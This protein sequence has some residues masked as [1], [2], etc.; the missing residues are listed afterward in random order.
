MTLHDG[1]VLALPHEGVSPRVSL[2]FVTGGDEGSSSKRKR[3]PEPDAAALIEEL[4]MARNE[5]AVSAA[6]LGAYKKAAE[7][8]K[9][10]AD[11][12]VRR[13]KALGEASAAAFA[14]LER[15]LEDTRRRLRAAQEE[16]RASSDE[17]M[18]LCVEA[19]ELRALR[20]A[21]ADAKGRL[22]ERET[23]FHATVAAAHAKAVQCAAD[24]AQFC[25]ESVRTPPQKQPEWDSGDY[26]EG[27]RF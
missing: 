24:L 6:R 10:E 2:R 22:H 17:A 15:E 26:E 13:H 1:D 20:R 8:A 3:E 19:A 21:M 14:D 9:A 4:R 16:L 12:D 5:A 27:Q 25:H 7:D 11:S 23:Q 18:R